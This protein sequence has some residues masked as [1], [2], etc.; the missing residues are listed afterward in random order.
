LSRFT[1]YSE[2]CWNPCFGIG[3]WQMETISDFVSE[4]SFVQTYWPSCSLEATDH[5]NFFKTIYSELRESHSTIVFA[6]LEVFISTLKLHSEVWA[7]VKVIDII[8]D[9]SPKKLVAIAAKLSPVEF[10]QEPTVSIAEYICYAH[11]ANM[12]S[13]ADS[14]FHGYIRPPSTDPQDSSWIPALTFFCR[15]VTVARPFLT[16]TVMTIVLMKQAQKYANYTA[17]RPTCLLG[18]SVTTNACRQYCWRSDWRTCLYSL[19]W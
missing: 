18:I 15:G 3:W 6:A 8:I 4:T 12:L 19:F 16:K 10:A 1:T 17:D 11:N 9:D 2:C 14:M 7:L 5:I 13:A